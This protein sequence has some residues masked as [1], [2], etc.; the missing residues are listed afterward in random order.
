MPVRSCK[1]TISCSLSASTLLLYILKISSLNSIYYL[2]YISR[3]ISM[4]ILI[5]FLSTQIVGIV[6]LSTRPSL[7]LGEVLEASELQSL[8]QHT[9]TLQQLSSSAPHTSHPS[10]WTLHALVCLITDIVSG[11]GGYF[12]MVLSSKA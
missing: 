6:C 2:T 9:L 4:Y 10:P 7:Q 3:V 12:S 5:A 8:V 1:K 11:E